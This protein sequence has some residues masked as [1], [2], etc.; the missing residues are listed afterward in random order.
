[1]H[2]L[3]GLRECNLRDKGDEGMVKGFEKWTWVE[4]SLNSVYHICLDY[5]LEFMK[6]EG[7]NIIKSKGF[8]WPQLEPFIFNLHIWDW[9]IKKVVVLIIKGRDR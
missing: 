4:E 7:R 9:L 5:G 2:R 3:I 8:V 6:E 1:M